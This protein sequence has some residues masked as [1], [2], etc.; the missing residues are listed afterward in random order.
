MV[1][2]SRELIGSRQMLEGLPLPDGL[3]AGDQ[4]D[5]LWRQHEEASIDP[6]AIAQGLLFEPTN[7]RL[8]IARETERPEARGRLSRS[9][10]CHSPMALVELDQLFDIDVSQ[11]IS[12]G[13]A[14][15]V[16]IE[17]TRGAFQ[18][19]AGH[20]IEARFNQRDP[21]WLGLP[22]MKVHRTFMSGSPSHGGSR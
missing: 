17:I 4:I 22:L 18:A 8:V 20:R 9:H 16:A 21:P 15:R 14:K 2:V 1:L 10:C 12:I 3:V 11:T 5:H 7:V 13:E 6:A 19:S